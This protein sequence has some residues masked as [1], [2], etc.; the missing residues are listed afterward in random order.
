VNADWQEGRVN[1][2]YRL[3]EVTLFRVGFAALTFNR[4]FSEAS[5][6]DLPELPALNGVSRTQVC[7]IRSQPVSA[8]LPRIGKA[9]RW[10]RYVPHQYKRFYVDLRGEFD[11][12][13]KRFSSKT[14]ST[15]TRK[16]RK[17]AEASGG[18][19]VWREYRTP[20]EL[21]AFLAM[22]LELSRKTYQDRLLGS[23]LPAGDDFRRRTLEAATR[24]EVRGYLLFLAGRPVAYVLCP[25]RD[26]V[27]VYEYV[28]FDPEQHQLSPGT[29]LQYLILK[30]LFDG[31]GY[32]MF[33]FTEGEGPQKA[34][35]AT[36]HV[37]CADIYFYRDTVV[38]AVA[39]R[40]HAALDRFS[41]LVAAGLDRIGLKAAIK[42]AIRKAA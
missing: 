22:A 23:G 34:L 40:L 38:N 5:P 29:V 8:V 6:D 28:G 20:E 7:V 14:R 18:E 2:T 36:H 31:G 16:V 21:E 24:S 12:Y 15:L 4:P 19:I 17:F 25:L 35:F 3:G 42:R 26:G 11:G 10:I 32:R 37:S 27:L 33:D 39:V 13:L 30:H 9:G 1:L 41:D